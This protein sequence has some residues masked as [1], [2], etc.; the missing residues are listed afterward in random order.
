MMN[1][2]FQ[3]AKNILQVFL[4]P[5]GAVLGALVTQ[6]VAGTIIGYNMAEV[7]LAILMEHTAISYNQ[8]QR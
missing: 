4:S 7:S 2:G 8:K 1:I 3:A 5:F 6:S